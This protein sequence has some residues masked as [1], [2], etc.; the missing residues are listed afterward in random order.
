MRLRSENSFSNFSS[1]VWKGSKLLDRTLVSRPQRLIVNK[2]FWCLGSRWSSYAGSGANGGRQ[3]NEKKN[4]KARTAVARL[5]WR[6]K[7]N[8]FNKSG[9]KELEAKEERFLHGFSADFCCCCLLLLLL[10]HC[11][12]QRCFA[13]FVKKVVCIIEDCQ[14]MTFGWENLHKW[15]GE[16]K[17]FY[18]WASE[19]NEKLRHKEFWL[20]C[21]TLAIF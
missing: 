18:R 14:S 10:C 7:A 20:V 11:F 15:K 19:L 17:R 3:R 2:A 21:A 1:P 8:H 6:Q 5:P 9:I 16:K 12:A 4:L 13:C